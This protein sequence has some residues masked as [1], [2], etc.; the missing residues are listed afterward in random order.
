MARERQT[1]CERAVCIAMVIRNAREQTPTTRCTRA[2]RRPTHACTCAATT[3][4]HDDRAATRGRRP[5]VTDL[6]VFRFLLGDLELGELL[7][8][9]GVGAAGAALLQRGEGR[10][11]L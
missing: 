8:A 1:A 2:R 10:F 9:A 3:E 4:L 7:G 11:D 5:V 6:L